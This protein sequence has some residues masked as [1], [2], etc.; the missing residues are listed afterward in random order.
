MEDGKPLDFSVVYVGKEILP[1]KPQ[2]RAGYVVQL[3]VLWFCA[4]KEISVASTIDQLKVTTVLIKRYGDTRRGIAVPKPKIMA[5]LQSGLILTPHPLGAYRN[6]PGFL[7]WRKIRPVVMAALS[8][9]RTST[10]SLAASGRFNDAVQGQGNIHHGWQGH[11]DLVTRSGRANVWTGEEYAM[12]TSSIARS[13][14]ARSSTT[15]PDLDGDQDRKLL[16]TYSVGPHYWRGDAVIEVW[17]VAKIA[18]HLKRYNRVG[19]ATMPSPMT[20]T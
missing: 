9:R 11:T 6:A 5:R 19:E 20:T 13:F 15:S 3:R 16:Y 1:W 17:G 8:S 18:K 4:P 7:T 10:W 14:P 2:H 12:G